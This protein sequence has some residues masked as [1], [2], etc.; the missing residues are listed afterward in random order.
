MKQL[1]ENDDDKTHRTSKKILLAI[2]AFILLTIYGI[3]LL[4]GGGFIKNIDGTE[5][6]SLIKQGTKII[7]VRTTGEFSTGHISGAANIPLNELP[8]HVNNLDKE[9]PMIVVCLSG[10]RSSQASE[11]LKSRGFKKVYNLSGGMM[12]WKGPVTK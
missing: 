8:N 12:A 6:E 3:S 2:G 9:E 1:N 7:D 10:N 5:A 4:F 11:Y